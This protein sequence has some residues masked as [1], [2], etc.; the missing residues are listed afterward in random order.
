M[1]LVHSIRTEQIDLQLR[2]MVKIK[3]VHGKIW[4]FNAQTMTGI[5]YDNTHRNNWVILFVQ[6]FKIKVHRTTLANTM[7]H[8]VE[9]II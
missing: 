7:P 4:K 2:I 3:D 8:V 6:G 1:P 9:D 5:F